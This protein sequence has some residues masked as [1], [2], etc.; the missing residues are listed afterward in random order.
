MAQLNTRIQL[1]YDSWSAWDSVKGTFKPLKGEICIVNPGTATG[2]VS[3]TPCLIK[4]G[5]GTDYFKDLPWLSAV[6]ADV[7][8]WAKQDYETFKTNIAND[9]QL[10]TNDQITALSARVTS[11][12]T[13]VGDSTKGLVKAVAD[14]TAAIS[15][16]IGRATDAE[17]VLSG[18][19]DV[20][21]G[22][23]EG[24]IAKAEADAKTY[25]DGLNSTLAARVTTNETAIGVL[26]GAD[27][28]TGS[29]AKQ[30]KDAVATETQNRID[31]INGLDTRLDTIEGTG[32]GSIAKAE[33]NAKAYTD[34]E[35]DKVEATLTSVDGR[36]TS[37][38]AAIE[39]LN[40][41][42]VGSVDKKVADAIA[43]V[44]AEAPTD[45][46]TLKEIADYIASD[47]TGAAELSNKVNK[48]AEDIGKNAAA[49]ADN[50]TAIEG[51]DA[52]ILALQGKVTTLETKVDVEKVST[53]IATAKGEA[54]NDA[55][56][57]A[58]TA[59]GNAKSYAD[60]EIG[61]VAA[62]V[63]T[64]ENLL[65]GIGGAE[66]PATVLAA[67]NTAKNE[68]AGQV[69]GL[70][71]GQVKANKEAI[72]AINDG[73]TGILATAK[74]YTDGEIDKVEA[75]IA[76][77]HTV[78]TTGNFTDLNDMSDDTTNYVIIYCGTASIF[79][80]NI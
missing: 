65:E 35:I 42:G 10:A 18:R 2:S 28:V 46:D 4:V 75:Q 6:A 17:N 64:N 34:A 57:K 9:L 55:T 74:G 1:K 77:L 62:R 8:D 36:V 37:N 51:N 11:L 21:E 41:T 40:G 39:V 78:A 52:D 14:N 54:A 27:T 66:E 69:T 58:N 53:A 50:K 15:G 5:N 45:F 73:T 33:A 59:E 72:E 80:D 16:E 79:A 61:K 13:T 67:I 24:S 49:I 3:N 68:V 23:G 26:N 63:T 71:N 43:A 31:A 20:I 12:E 22:D 25:A 38:T 48:N 30:I 56:S 60:T 44:V 29:V 19:L 76:G 70:A 32:E 7:H 47:T